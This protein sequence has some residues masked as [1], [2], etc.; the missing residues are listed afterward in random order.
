MVLIPMVSQ[1]TG[2]I[3]AL[4]VAGGSTYVTWMCTVRTASGIHPITWHVDVRKATRPS[5]RTA[6][7]TAGSAKDTAS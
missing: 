6:T 3:G 1:E 5:S 2:V 4:F 7:R